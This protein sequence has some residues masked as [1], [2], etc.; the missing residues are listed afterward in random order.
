L[1]LEHTRTIG[2]RVVNQARVGFN[3]IAF[4]A[5]AG[6]SAAPADYRLETRASAPG[7][8]VFNVAGAF[9]FGGPANIP[10]GRTDTTVLLSDTVSYAVG[11]HAIKVGGEYR[12]STIASWMLDA[13]TFNFP[14]VAAFAAGTANSFSV[15]VGDRAADIS[16][17][18]FGGFV[19][20]S[21]RAHPTLTV[22]AGVRYEW[23][24]TPTE[25]DDRFI[26]FDAPTA[27]LEPV[28]VHR[29]A[30]YEQ[31]ITTSSRGPASPGIPGV[32]AAR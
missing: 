24:V 14:T 7:L 4:E 9:T 5:Q 29:A 2:S 12:R 1:T 21:F 13:G 15:V 10:Q 20:D 8:P 17:R 25:R 6:A 31:T 18:A 30:V 3:R 32:T 16:Q 11:R 23:N 27:S 28:G 26:V 19:Q 22:D